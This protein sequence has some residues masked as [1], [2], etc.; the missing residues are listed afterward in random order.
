METAR[1]LVAVKVTDETARV[2]GEVVGVQKKVSLLS[3]SSPPSSCTP[4]SFSFLKER[5]LVSIV[6]SLVHS[7]MTTFTRFYSTNSSC[8]SSSI[9]LSACI[10]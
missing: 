4:R 5:R 10:L 7:K 3:V 8:A 9:F 6:H 2:P 1:T